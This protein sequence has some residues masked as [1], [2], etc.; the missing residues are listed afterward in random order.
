MWLQTD[1]NSQFWNTMW[2]HPIKCVSESTQ[3]VPVSELTVHQLSTLLLYTGLSFP[4]HAISQNDKCQL[5]NYELCQLY[6]YMYMQLYSVVKTALTTVFIHK[7]LI[8]SPRQWVVNA[9]NGVHAWHAAACSWDLSLPTHPPAHWHCH[10]L[11]DRWPG[12]VHGGLLYFLHLVVWHLLLPPEDR[13]SILQWLLYCFTVD[14]LP[15]IC[16]PHK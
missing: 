3:S 14:N 12:D 2:A 9:V 13:Y 15:L 10:C 8:Y 5:S 6:T 11:S 4:T 7:C 1:I 16:L